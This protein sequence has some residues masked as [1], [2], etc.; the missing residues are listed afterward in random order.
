MNS[1]LS[2]RIFFLKM[3]EKYKD[4]KIKDFYQTNE[5]GLEIILHTHEDS[6]S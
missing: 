4:K 2:D 3:K 1:L 5:M 6:A